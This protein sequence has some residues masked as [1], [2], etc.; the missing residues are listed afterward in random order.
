MAV[1][2][3]SYTDALGSEV[4]VPEIPKRIVS[5]VPSQT[6]LLFDLG[7]EHH[8]VGITKFC[9]HPKSLVQTKTKIGGTKNFNFDVIDSLQP[10]LIIANK[11]ENF[12][13]GI[14]K[15]KEKYPV[16]TSDIK[17]LADALQM[18]LQIG[19]ITKT[20]PKAK[21]LVTEIQEEFK[22]YTSQ[23]SP[24]KKYISEKKVAYF[25]WRKP[26]M[27]AGNGT[28]IDAMLKEMNCNNVFGHLERYPEI[29][30]EMLSEANPSD[31]FLSSEPYP[32]KEKHI[33]ELQKI[34]PNA[35]I[36]LVDGEMFSWYGSRLLHTPQYLATL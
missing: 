20:S 11:E 7:L 32:F 14:L 30:Q 13:E 28:F 34:V 31:I 5:L 22:K 23:K 16:W 35:H 12:K 10:D 29:S 18:I 9:I 6:E 27:V 26:Y 2:F 1:S 24:L 8:I 36:Q 17:N 21:S 33:L 15:L 19:E 4:F 3:S 25:I